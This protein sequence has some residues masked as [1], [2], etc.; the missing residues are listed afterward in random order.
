MAN[1]SLTALHLALMQP[2]CSHLYS[3]ADGSCFCLLKQG[4]G[5]KWSYREAGVG[6]LLCFG[7]STAPS[8]WDGGIGILCWLWLKSKGCMTLHH[9]ASRKLRSGTCRHVWHKVSHTRLRHP[10]LRTWQCVTGARLHCVTSGL[11]WGLQCHL[12]PVNSHTACTRQIQVVTP[13]ASKSLPPAAA[14][15]NVGS[16]CSQCGRRITGAQH[17]CSTCL[18]HHCAFPRCP[19][20]DWFLLL[21]GRLMGSGSC[22]RPSPAVP[23]PLSCY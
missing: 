14:G 12:A 19:W 6:V 22:G 5:A 23:A 8:V 2:D 15:G 4:K 10:F 11:P 21:E 17:G 1:P 9:P 16:S 20:L 7:I 13:Q 18:K 3:F